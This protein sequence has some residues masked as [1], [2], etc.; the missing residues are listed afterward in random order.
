MVNI[1]SNFGN[2]TDSVSKFMYLDHF[3]RIYHDIR[4]DLKKYTKI[5][6]FG[7]ANG[8]LKTFF[9]D[10]LTTVDIDQTNDPDS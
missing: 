4:F 10:R 7:G 6:D 8:K 3:A 2:W 5:E 1:D 9:G